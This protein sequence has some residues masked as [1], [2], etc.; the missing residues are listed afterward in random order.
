MEKDSNKNQSQRCAWTGLILGILAVLLI[1]GWLVIVCL[2]ESYTPAQVL[3]YLISLCGIGVVCLCGLGFSIPGLVRALRLDLKKWPSVSG[4]VLS[5]LSLLS[6]PSVCFMIVS[7]H[8]VHEP[9]SI[10]F[11]RM[12]EDFEPDE[13]CDSG[14][15]YQLTITPEG[16]VM[17]HCDDEDEELTILT[18]TAENLDTDLCEWLRDSVAD[19]NMELTVSAGIDVDYAFVA[20]VIEALQLNGIKKIRLETFRKDVDDDD[21][22]VDDDD[23]F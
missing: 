14:E 20:D 17:F 6:L 22:Y 2:P 3:A 13:S 7:A 8:V 4:I 19:K 5:A 18:S 15:S 12:S 9:I 23:D 16:V 21:D 11:Y 1:A 10:E